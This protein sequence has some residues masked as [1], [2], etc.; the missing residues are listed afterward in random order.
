MAG[1]KTSNQSSWYCARVTRPPNKTIR[2]SIFDAT[3]KGFITSPS[4]VLVQPSG[5][6]GGGEL[7]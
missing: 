1:Q 6:A 2:E 3:T 5:S 7:P 4:L